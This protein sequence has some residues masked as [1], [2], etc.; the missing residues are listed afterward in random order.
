MREICTDIRYI[1]IGTGSGDRSDARSGRIDID[2]FRFIRYPVCAGFPRAD[3]N[4]DCK[5]DLD[6]LFVL[7]EEWLLGIE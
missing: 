2:E 1:L 3:M 4:K 5:V 7:V 6:D